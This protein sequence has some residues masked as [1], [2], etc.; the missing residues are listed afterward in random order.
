[1]KECDAIS[2]NLAELVQVLNSMKSLPAI[3]IRESLKKSSSL[4]IQNSI[5]EQSRNIAKVDAVSD[6]KAREYYE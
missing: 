1:M 2:L 5:K 4:W 6:D 3:E